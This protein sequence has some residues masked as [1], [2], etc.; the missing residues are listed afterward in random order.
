MWEAAIEY[1][2]SSSGYGHRKQD[3]S[4]DLSSLVPGSKKFRKLLKSRARVSQE[5]K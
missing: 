4:L 3:S 1:V 2:G 5:E